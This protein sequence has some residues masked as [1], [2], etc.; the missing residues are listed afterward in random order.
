MPTRISRVY[1]VL[2]L[3]LLLASA[4][5]VYAWQVTAVELC[6]LCTIYKQQNEYLER[7]V[8]ALTADTTISAARLQTQER[9]IAENKQRLAEL[10]QQVASQKVTL[11]DTE[12]RLATAQEQ[13]ARQESQLSA[14][15]TELQALRARPP[16]FTFS[17]PPG[18]PQLEIQ[19]EDIKK[20]VEKAY[21]IIQDVYG[22]PYATSQIAITLS[23]SLDI[24][25][26]IGQTTIES[27]PNGFKVT[28]TLPDFDDGSAS[29]LTTLVHEIGHAFTGAATPRD[30]AI[31]EGIVVGATELIMD[32]LVKESII[33]PLSQRYL[34]IT[35][36]KY[37]DLNSKLRLPADTN[38]FYSQSNISDVYQMIGMAWY[39][40]AQ[41]D[42]QIFRKL[43]DS[44]NGSSRRGKVARPPSVLQALRSSI[45][46][47]GSTPIDTYIAENQAFNPR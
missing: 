37:N 13:T 10:E 19:Q 35:P 18:S 7:R 21:P 11:Q 36:T 39:R 47:V 23:D 44:Y 4:V 14:N 34:N 32:R 42:P 38:A 24:P 22:A 26:S 8:T 41:Q 28:I 3:I 5:F 15:A 2:T 31:A 16:L 30:A 20:F 17:S 1:P 40:I 25:G 12:T 9:L 46:K 29:D 33:P 43:H 27:G 45:E 6:S